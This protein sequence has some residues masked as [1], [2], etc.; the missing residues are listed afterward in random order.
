M[1]NDSQIRQLYYVNNFVISAIAILLINY[2]AIIL[3]IRCWK[4]Y[5]WHHFIHQFISAFL[6]PGFS[7][8]LGSRVPFL[9][10][11]TYLQVQNPAASNENW[12]EALWTLRIS[13]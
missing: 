10:L 11:C 12:W 3:Q 13:F 9:V 1:L 8:F 2:M 6:S 5:I 7:S 4:C